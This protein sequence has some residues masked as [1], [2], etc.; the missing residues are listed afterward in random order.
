MESKEMATAYVCDHNKL[1]AGE[2]SQASDE[3]AGKNQ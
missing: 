2:R 1:G 3:Y